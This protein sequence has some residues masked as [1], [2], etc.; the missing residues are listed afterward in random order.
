M[1]AAERSLSASGEHE[2]VLRMRLRYQ[3]LMRDE[4]VSAI[5]RL[6]EGKVDAFLSG[7][8]LEPDL[9]VE[10]FVLDRP[11]PVDPSDPTAG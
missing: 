9:A 11:V 2:A 3:E 6:T 4:L 10:L 1:T 7:N 5:E 8:H